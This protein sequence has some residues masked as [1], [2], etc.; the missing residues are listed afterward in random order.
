MGIAEKKGILS[1]DDPLYK[2]LGEDWAKTNEKKLI[3]SVMIKHLLGMAS[4]LAKENQ[5]SPCISR[6]CLELIHEPGTEW[7]YHKANIEL[8]VQVLEKAS[9]QSVNRFLF[10]HLRSTIGLNGS[11]TEVKGETTYKSNLR[12]MARFGILLLNQGEWANGE[13]VLKD[14]YVKQLFTSSQEINPAFSL[15]NWINSSEIQRI[16]GIDQARDGKFN[17]NAPDDLLAAIGEGGQLINVVPSKKMTWVSFGRNGSAGKIDPKLNNQ[18]WDKINQLSCKN[19]KKA[20]KRLGSDAKDFLRLTSKVPIKRILVSDTQ[21]KIHYA[22][23]INSNELNISLKQFN[24]G[25]Y[26]AK[27]QFVNDVISTQRFSVK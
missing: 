10:D 27:I 18:I 4:G 11:F 12:N 24:K 25:Y 21:G 15:F 14:A 2:Y 20:L 23:E 16:A 7:L 9:G 22:A 6:S 17:E 13:E 5:F 19:P 26:Y 1:L 8:A 3:E